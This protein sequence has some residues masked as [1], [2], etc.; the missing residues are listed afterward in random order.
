MERNDPI[1]VF[2]RC[3]PQSPLRKA[4]CEAVLERVLLDRG[5]RLWAIVPIGVT[6]DLPGSVPILRTGAHDF[7]ESSRMR[8]EAATSSKIY[9]LLDDDQLPLGA[10][11]ARRG[12]DLLASQPGLAMVS[13]W[14]V[15]GEVVG[16]SDVDSDVFHPASTGTPCW[17]RRGEAFAELPEGQPAGDFDLRLCAMLGRRGLRYGMASGLRHNHLG[18]EY[19]QVVAGHWAA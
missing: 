4:L 14:S 3:W 5:A 6:L 7:P 18:Y 1:D 15:N 17:V 19:S 13:S 16:V 9:C 12:A 2:V 10:D 8:A 11:W